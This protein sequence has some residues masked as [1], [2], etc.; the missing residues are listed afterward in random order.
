MDNGSILGEVNGVACPDNSGGAQKV[1]RAIWAVPYACEC[2]RNLQME[3]HSAFAK[4]PEKNVGLPKPQKFGDREW[5]VVL[6]ALKD[7]AD[8][9]CGS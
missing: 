2:V 6:E 7:L 5:K 1:E 9:L 3:L 8:M 4:G